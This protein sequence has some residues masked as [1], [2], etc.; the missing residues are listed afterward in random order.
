MTGTATLNIYSGTGNGGTLLYSA[1]VTISGAGNFWQTF[2]ISPTVAV[3]GGSVYTY[4]VV[5]IQGGGL[6][7]PYGV[8]V[9]GPVN[10]YVGGQNE[11]GG[12]WDEVFKVYLQ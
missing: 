8:Q 4:E 9:A 1:G 7:D 2:I 10:N 6:P 11:M 5:P 3:N 12:G